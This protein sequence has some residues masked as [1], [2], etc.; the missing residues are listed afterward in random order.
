MTQ[1]TS[2]FFEAPHGTK[3]GYFKT[4]GKAPTV[5]FMGGLMSDMSGTKALFLETNISH[6]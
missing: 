6:C 2:S 5:V 4:H 1:P 3:I